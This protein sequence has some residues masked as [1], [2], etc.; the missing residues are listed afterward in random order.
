[1]KKIF[2]SLLVLLFLCAC[3]QQFNKDGWLKE[4]EKRNDM[5]YNLIN[6]YE[7]VGMTEEEII[8]LLGKPEQKIDKP[9]I[10]YVYYLGTA[11]LMGVSVSL[12]RLQFDQNGKL[13]SHEIDYS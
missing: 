7:L 12:L 8:R 1:M 13:D 9:N 11:G 5:V 10:Q 6:K 3:D 4:P 2:L